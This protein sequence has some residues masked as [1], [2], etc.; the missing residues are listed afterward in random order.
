MIVDELPLL[1]L[2]TKLREA[3]LQVG[4]DEYQLVLRSLQAGFGIQDRDA[5]KRL[6]RTLWVKSV[7]ERGLFDYLFE[8]VMPNI[9]AQS[10]AHLPP[11]QPEQKNEADA[12]RRRISRRTRYLALGGAFILGVGIFLGVGSYINKTP[13]TEPTPTTEQSNGGN[14]SN[15]IFWGS[16]SI[17]ALTAGSIVARQVVQWRTKR[18][19]SNN[20]F[21]PKSTASTPTSAQPPELTTEIEDEVQVAQAVQHSTSKDEDIPDSGL[22]LKSDYFP[23]TRRQ[24]KQSWRYLRRPIREGTPAE[25]DVEATVNQIGRQ[26]MLLELV[27]VPRR[28]NRAEL[29]LLIDR[30]GSMVPFHAL[31]QPLA[32]TALRGGR[33]GK[34]DIYY[35]HNC[36]IDYLYRDRHHQEA[37]A[38]SSI[39]DRISERTA[40]LIFSDGGAARGGYSPDRV[41]LTEEFLEQL[42]T[43]VRYIAWFNP[44]PKSRW[45][46]TTAGA[47]ARMVPMFAVSRSGLQSAINVLRGR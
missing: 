20:T 3:G 41:E 29:M 10:P 34:A 2:F 40:V 1:E 16:L 32:E 28:V 39:L 12:G 17:I 31:S 9:W 35:F 19:V 24:M 7:E 8:R 6:C 27:L 42:K 26:G 44:M 21:V 18:R 38:I 46:G 11:D 30:D 5:L 43:K 45:E 4:I 23:V 13:T 37:E 22:I 15:I 25:L 36:P 33:L 47:I 14:E